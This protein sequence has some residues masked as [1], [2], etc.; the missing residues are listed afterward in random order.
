MPGDELGVGAERAR[1]DHRVRRHVHVGDR[2]EVPV[3]ADRSELGRDRRRDGLGQR[4]VVDGAERGAGGVRAP[5]LPLEPRDVAA[6]L[7]DREQDVV[8]LRAQLTAQRREAAR[9]EGTL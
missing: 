5:R 6:L 7:V 9:A 3:H 2:R 1:P 8:A 4:R